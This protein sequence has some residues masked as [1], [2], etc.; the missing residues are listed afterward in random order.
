MQV[1]RVPPCQLPTPVG[2]PTSSPRSPPLRGHPLTALRSSY[3]GKGASP[4]PAGAEWGGGWAG[5]SS[6]ETEMRSCLLH[7]PPSRGL[8]RSGWHPGVC[9]RMCGAERGSWEITEGARGE[10]WHRAQQAARGSGGDLELRLLQE[11]RTEKGK[12]EYS[13]TRPTESKSVGSAKLFR[14]SGTDICL[15]RSF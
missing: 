6:G 7:F 9:E 5:V 13:R 11:D 14:R 2:L 3:H 10:W 1:Q 4:R 12:H 15:P 8:C